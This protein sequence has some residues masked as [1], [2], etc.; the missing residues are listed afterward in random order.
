MELRMVPWRTGEIAHGWT[1]RSPT[2]SDRS[3][4]IYL[5][6]GD[7]DD[8]RAMTYAITYNIDIR[9][10]ISCQSQYLWG[11][12]LCL[13]RK[14]D[15]DRNEDVAGSM[16][17]LKKFVGPRVSLAPVTV[18]DAD[19]AARWLND[20]EVAVPLGDEAWQTITPESQAAVAGSDHVFTVIANDGDV[21]IGRCLLYGVNQVDRNANVG[22]FIGDKQYW[23]QGL[24]GETLELLLE[25]AFNLLNLHSVMLGVFEFNTRAL[26]CY[27]RLGFREIGRRRQT[28]L[29]AGTYYDGVM[30]DLLADEFRGHR[31]RDLMA[32]VGH[33][34][35]AETTSA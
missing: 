4:S 33:E 17:M 16:V 34:T 29:I 32:A 2:E 20:L 1:F 24:G 14:I 3:V 25:Y 8:A 26:S 15:C 31:I 22:I 27:R 5:I 11:G 18:G 28:R 12:Y 6:I 30:M 21:P 23:N 10:L 35:E 19:L 9:T 13:G 7:D